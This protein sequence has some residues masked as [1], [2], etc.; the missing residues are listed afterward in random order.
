[1][2]NLIKTL[3]MNYYK[4]IIAENRT[5]FKAI[6][7]IVNGLL[8]RKQESPLPPI[9]PLSKLVEEFSEFFDSKIAKIMNHLQSNIEGDPQRFI[10]KE[11]HFLTKKRL[12]SFNPIL[13][14][15]VKK[16]V[17]DTPNKSCELDPIN[18]ILLK[19]NIEIIAP[20]I[21]NIANCSFTSGKVCQDLKDA[22]LHPL[23]KGTLD[24]NLLTSFRPV[25]DLTYLSKL[26][27]RLA[28]KQLISYTESTGMMECNQSAYHKNHSTETCL[29]KLKTD[30]V[31]AINKKEVMCLVLLDLSAAFDSLEHSL[32]LN[33][34]KY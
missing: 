4:N 10:Y 1:M 25:S 17:V 8:H 9:T 15:D 3:Q 31:D 12:Q 27:E 32:I 19:S 24:H 22:L 16:L 2:A 29:L 11:D 34:L 20:I 13:Y 18:T 6:Y 33:R 30:I 23:Q 21:A 14:D 28:A 7:K 5:D 26:L